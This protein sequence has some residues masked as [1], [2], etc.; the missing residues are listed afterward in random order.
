[1]NL[2]RTKACETACISSQT[3]DSKNSFAT[4]NALT[5]SRVATASRDSLI[6]RRFKPVRIRLWIERE[7]FRHGIVHVD[8]MKCSH[9]VLSKSRLHFATNRYR[10]CINQDGEAPVVVIAALCYWI[11][12]PEL[13]LI[14]VLWLRGALEVGVRRKI[15]AAA[16]LLIAGSAAFSTNAKASDTDWKLYGSSTVNGDTDLC[17]FDLK[18]A[19]K[20]TDNHIKVWAKCLHKKDA[21]GLDIK[22]DY[23]GK[24]LDNV[25]RKMIDRYIPPI[26]LV[27]DTNFDQA[28]DVATLEEIADVA[29]IQPSARIFYELDCSKVMLRELS[30]EVRSGSRNS[31]SEWKYIAPETNGARLQKILCEKSVPR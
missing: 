10:Q 27:E 15:S 5:A 1:L 18:G 14:K 2:P 28:T 29:S 12:K 3:S 16:A 13:D 20:G 26:A 23:G 4:I 24:I 22:K 8:R 25:A 9:Y 11:A 31:A 7:G 21:E 19:V 30:I 17:F 6:G